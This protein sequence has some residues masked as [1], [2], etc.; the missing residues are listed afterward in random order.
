[1]KKLGSIPRRALAVAASATI[2][3]IGAVALASP[4]SAHH[5]EVEGVPYC[6]TDT[7]QWVVTWTVNSFA[8][9][10]ASAYKLVEV[11]STPATH[12][13][14]N[15]GVTDTDEYPHRT[16]RELVGE[17]RLPGDAT[18]ASLG[19][20]AQWSNGYEESELRRG[21]LT[22]EG[23]CEQSPEPSVEHTS[24][25]DELVLTVDNPEDAETIAVQITT[26]AGDEEVGDV[27]AGGSWTVSFPA[28]EE[29]TYQVTIDE[30]VYAEGSWENPGDCDTEI[31]VPIAWR[32]DCESLT[33]EVTNPLDEEAIEA[34][35]T[36]GEETKTLT[37]EP[38]GTA[39]ATFDAEP[40]TVA[41][42]TIG[43]ESHEVAW[44]QPEDCEDPGA[45]GGLPET[46]ASTGIVI[47]A[48]LALLALGGGLF[49]VARRRRVTFTA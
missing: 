31:E 38:G 16:N 45:G 35:V 46:G 15:I 48:A 1:M 33:V 14:S 34:T 9:R 40:G 28:D 36:S 18:S 39:E 6:D 21:S 25:C 11:E 2:G 23:P 22:F 32:F 8:P 20:R 12:P 3:L 17:Q 7:G 29:V 37:V 13:V 4:A 19:V 24:T 10:E 41:T 49:L 5:S 26:S 42:V 44:E 27:E 47:G 30:T 43:E